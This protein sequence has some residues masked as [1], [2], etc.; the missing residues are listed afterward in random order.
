[1]LLLRTADP[2]EFGLKIRE[3]LTPSQFDSPS[4][5]THKIR[6][7]ADFGLLDDLRAA[8]EQV[9]IESINDLPCDRHYLTALCNL[10]QAA[11]VA[12]STEHA[13]ALYDLLARYPEYYTADISF[14]SDGSV[15]HFL[16]RLA[17]LLGR[18]ADALSH[19]EYALEQNTRFELRPCAALTS[20]ELA[21]LLIDSPS[22]RDVPRAFTLLAQTQRSATEIGMGPLADAANRKA[23]ACG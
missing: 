4:T 11:C 16:G 3:S 13:R 23:R 22:V 7:M 14:H 12:Q 21:C 19:F 1:M 9:S 2:T 10:A 6:G 5:R 8:L 17:R 15:S 18:D 20:Y